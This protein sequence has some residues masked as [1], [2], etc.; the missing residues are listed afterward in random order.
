MNPVQ[1]WRRQRKIRS[2]LGK[3]GTIISWTIIAV[4]HDQR[5]GP[6]PYPVALVE[7]TDGRRIYGEIV[8]ADPD[9]ITTGATVQV[10]LRK[11]DAGA[12]DESVIPYGPKLVL[13]S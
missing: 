13:Q 9:Q 8:D 5:T 4:S 2:R 10:V 11:Y 3:I 12:D 6:V 7:L 1:Y